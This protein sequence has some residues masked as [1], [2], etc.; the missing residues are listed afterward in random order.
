R[1]F[2]GQSIVGPWIAVGLMVAGV[3]GVAGVAVGDSIRPPALH[4][5]SPSMQSLP[6]QMS[7]EEAAWREEVLG[8]HNGAI[9]IHEQLLERPALPDRVRVEALHRLGV[10]YSMKGNLPPA[11][12][13]FLKV[14][15]EFPDTEPFSQKASHNLLL[16]SPESNPSDRS[17][18]R[19]ER[20]FLG[21][22]ALVLDAALTHSETRTVTEVTGEAIGSLRMMRRQVSGEDLQSVD[23]TLAALESLETSW[24]AAPAVPRAPSSRTAWA[25]SAGRAW[26]I[27]RAS[28]LAPDD[29][30]ASILDCRDRLA[31]A[32]VVQDAAE[33]RRQA[34]RVARWADPVSHAGRDS[35]TA[36]YL[37][38]VEASMAAVAARAS[39]G[40]FGEARSVWLQSTRTL[41]RAF[42]AFTLHVPGL[43]DFPEDLR[44]DLV[45]VLTRIEEALHAI[46][47]PDDGGDPLGPM[48]DAMERL[49]EIERQWARSVGPTPAVP[50]AVGLDS[51]GRQRLQRWADDWRAVVA[52]LRAGDLPRAR[53]LLKP[54]EL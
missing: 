16:L 47:S 20:L 15:R 30:N 23:R 19:D 32:L 7:L 42:G 53:Q 44:P 52:T 48:A 8:H 12:T 22:L 11:V 9:R 38:L 46:E 21:D 2:F 45:A 31:R 26:M 43:S 36:G 17:W 29:A 49:S 1:F 27:D 25:R 34:G 5:Q 35:L 24:E 33:I 4:A 39:T 37:G 3:A 14:V 41:N 54:Y 18:F 50:P 28:L 13:L 51:P 6:L 10:C 40:R